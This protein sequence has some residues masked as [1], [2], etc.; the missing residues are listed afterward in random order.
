M[1]KQ[2]LQNT[3]SLRNS[4]HFYTHDLINP[5]RIPQQVLLSPFSRGDRD[6]GMTKDRSGPH[7]FSAQPCL[8]SHPASKGGKSVTPSECPASPNPRNLKH[9][10][11][12]V[13][14]YGE[15]R[16]FQESFLEMNY[17]NGNFI[18]LELACSG[19]AHEGICFVPGSEG[20]S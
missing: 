20:A 13:L 1:I 15:S 4:K 11:K 18:L 10:N 2:N 16:A 8:V 5:G 9:L 6:P 14:S 19:K 7:I 17:W 12:A 3:I